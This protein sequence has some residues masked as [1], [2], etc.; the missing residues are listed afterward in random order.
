MEKLKVV[1]SVNILNCFIIG[2]EIVDIY[3]INFIDIFVV[4]IF[5]DDVVM[6]LFDRI[7]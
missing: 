3:D 2:C 6:G 4:V 5:V 7:E 1:V